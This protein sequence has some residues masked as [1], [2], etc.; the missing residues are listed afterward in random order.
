M[1]SLTALF[2]ALPFIFLISCE[3]PAPVA[4][5]PEPAEPALGEPVPK[6]SL[7]HSVVRVNSTS[8]AWNPGQPW[9]KQ[10]PKRLR[11]LAAIIAPGQVLTTA[12]MV[13]DA[14]YLELESPEGTRTTQAKI[15]AVDYE[16]NLALLAAADPGESEAFFADTVPFEI[17][18]VPG[19]GSRLEIIQI[20]DNGS[21]L[22]TPGVLQSVDVKSSFL[23]NQNFL[24]YLVKASM[25]GASSSFSLPVLKDDKLIGIL[26]GYNSREQIS[27][28]LAVDIIARFLENASAETYS[29]FP[30]LGIS[31]ARTDDPSLR[32]F[33]KLDD[34]QGGLYISKV[35]TGSAADNAGIK[36]GDV[37]LAADDLPINRRGFY[38]HP[39]YGSIAWGHIVRGEKSTGDTI[40]LSLLRD[41]K[42][43]EITAT[44]TREEPG[45]RLVP[46]YLF[47]TPPNFLVKGG[48]IFQELS[49][50]LL[51]AF[52]E[53]WTSRA[54]LNLLDAYEN[55][56]KFEDSVSRIIFLSGSIPTPATV[57]Y[58][59][60]RNLIVHK[61]NGIEITDMETL[62][63]AFD[64]PDADNLHSIEFLEEN[65]TV[66]LDEAVSTQVD[67][68]LLQRGLTRLSRAD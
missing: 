46:D 50:P 58:E 54:P 28:I 1:K 17:A 59:R 35:R 61:V 63:S 62:I 18:S 2:A 36:V 23:P 30:T 39:N 57:G 60:L 29:G 9:E 56:E 5:T 6:P 34:D 32:Q 4:I 14:T 26:L 55:P 43:L 27:D 15:I 37:L 49:R 16:A 31:V 24:N 65:F 64:K 51:E 11:S 48:L 20:E 10:P 25:Q 19:I 42:S 8:Q 12:E 7:I 45:D 44:L 40:K 13:A 47:D 67:S 68:M 52:G 66:H 38:D 41:G 21:T 3:K 22:I 33:L 53:E